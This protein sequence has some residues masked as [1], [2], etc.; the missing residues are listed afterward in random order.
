MPVRIFA[1]IN[2]LFIKFW[3]V[4]EEIPFLKKKIGFDSS[5]CWTQIWIC[6]FNILHLHSILQFWQIIIE[7]KVQNPNFNV[8]KIE[9][10][11][12]HSDW[13]GNEI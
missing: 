6:T 3:I 11:S 1:A 8:K 2:A 7:S 5:K 9:E 10:L 12:H 13:I 4:S